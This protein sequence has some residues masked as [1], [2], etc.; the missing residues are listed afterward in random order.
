[1]NRLRTK[2]AQLKSINQYREFSNFKGIDFTSF[3]YLGLRRHPLIQHHMMDALERGVS[4]GAGGSRLLRGHHD[5]HSLLEEYAAKFFDCEM[6][7]FMN[8]GFIANYSLFSTLP[9]RHDV[10]IYDQKVHASIKEGIH[11]S[12]A[13][14]IRFKHNDLV[15]LEHRIKQC[16]D[17]GADTIWIAIESLYSMDGDRAPL[18]EIIQIANKYEAMLIIDEAHA[19]GVFGDNGRGFTEGCH[20]DNI[21]SMHTCGKALGV[22]G[23][24]I[25]ASESIINY[26]INCCRP[27]IY[28]TAPSPLTASTVHFVLNL[29]AEH[30]ERRLQLLSLIQYAN[31]AF[32]NIPGFQAT[33][34]QILPVIVGD[35]AK[36][37]ILA[38]QLQ[39]DGFD[40]RAIRPPTVDTGCARLRIIISLNV[41]R[42]EIDKLARKL[43]T[44]LT[45]NRAKA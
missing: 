27:F 10:V 11:A 1:M 23:A 34:S 42:A 5:E 3:D 39:E 45:Y 4:F 41:T 35:N 8:S 37:L 28:S 18:S 7:L 31:N 36:A 32:Q 20:E 6:T 14:N 30:T 25:C 33:N 12:H 29:I 22:S 24:L 17:S 13:K 38:K 15:D 16:A 9:S 21:I 26:L 44:I 19:T 40:V 2:L 43:Q